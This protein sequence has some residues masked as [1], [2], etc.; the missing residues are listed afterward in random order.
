MTSDD[1]AAMMR[2]GALF[3]VSCGISVVMLL[4]APDAPGRSDEIRL[5]K[6]VVVIADG[7]Y[8]TTVGMAHGICVADVR[9]GW[10]IPL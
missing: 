9:E 1:A 5:S 2:P 3:R 10:W 4:D 7:C 8:G 6:A